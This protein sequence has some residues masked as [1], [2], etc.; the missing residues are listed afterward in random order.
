M[1]ERIYFISNMLRATSKETKPLQIFFYQT[2][3]FALYDGT[4]LR[5]EP[6]LQPG[7]EIKRTEMASVP[8]LLTKLGEDIRTYGTFRCLLP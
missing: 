7:I 5:I 2:G 1:Y 8:H 4:I 6:I 3:E